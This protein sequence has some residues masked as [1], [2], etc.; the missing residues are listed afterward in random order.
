MLMMR[1]LAS[2]AAYLAGGEGLANSRGLALADPA[3]VYGTG[4][5]GG[6]RTVID[7]ARGNR[8]RGIRPAQA[9]FPSSH[10]IGGIDGKSQRLP[11][12]R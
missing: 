2:E 10:R 4:R 5:A 1:A 6:V 8:G 11:F 3:G 12:P 7:P 9:P